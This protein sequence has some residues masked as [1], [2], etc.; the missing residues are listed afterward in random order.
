MQGEKKGSKLGEQ[1]YLGILGIRPSPAQLTD[2]KGYEGMKKH[3]GEITRK[4]HA[5]AEVRQK[6]I[7]G[8]PTE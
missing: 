6:Q 8:G 1:S 5:R 2:P 3:Q 4:K 7:Y